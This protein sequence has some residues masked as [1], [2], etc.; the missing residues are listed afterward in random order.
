M[1]SVLGVRTLVRGV[2]PALAALACAPAGAW[3][4]VDTTCV[5]PLTK[6]DPATVNVA[7]PDEAAI[8]WT[9][10]YQAAPGT[11]LRVTGRFPHARYFSLNVYDAAQ[12]PL[13][14]IA[15]VE[16]A[17]DAGS[18]NP[19]REGADRTAAK[20]D[21]TAFVD[22]GPVPERRAANTVYTGT[23]QNGL[24]NLT[25][26]FILRVYTPDRGRDETGGVGLPTVTLE[27]ADGG[28]P[29]DSACAGIEKP[30]VA[31][32]NEQLA[33]ASG[34]PVP[35]ELRAP[36]V[37]PPRWLK[38]RNLVQTAN[39]L[40]TGNPF[41]DDVPSPLDPLEALGGQ[42]A[43]LSNVHN[44]YVSTAVN[45]AYG[46]V[47]LTEMRAP[48]F[49]DTRPGP[50]RMPGGQLRYFSLCTN[51]IA[52]QRF[53][54][55]RTDDQTAVG[56]GGRVRYVVS[57]AA[58]RPAGATPEYGYTFVPLGP[59]A[60]SA[61]ILRHMLP[62][63]GFPEAIQR[64]EPRKEAATMGAYLPRSRYLRPGEALP[65]RAAARSEGPALATPVGGPRR[66]VSRRS[67]TIRLRRDLRSAT[68]FVAG[69]RVRT[70]RGG[71]LRAP[72]DLRG[73]PAGRVPVRIVA[74]TRSG[75]RVTSVRTYRT[76]VPRRG[77]EARS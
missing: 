70:L 2:V 21:Y 23:G 54:A 9:G 53:V 17:P 58:S 31:G 76:C 11:R 27:A 6:T 71:R 20:R 75:R 1:G 24:P 50:A 29:A 74:R 26:T 32:A 41:F 73:L 35:A 69:R 62:A 43:F 22:F 48:T 18:T 25:G 28:R 34:P 68:V 60:H 63:A 57:N 67:F 46:E 16:L 64:A 4:Q 77:G 39:A 5:L 66:C 19:Y 65:C 33:G 3:A 10:A 7:Y 55:C 59:G 52:S 36:G 72:V 30:P 12:R 38:F 61:L 8:Y 37:D 13:D 47:T 42:G 15:D 44:A 14:A 51:D 49:P 40:A 56:E 45:R